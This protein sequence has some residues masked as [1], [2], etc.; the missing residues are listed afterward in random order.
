MGFARLPVNSGYTPSKKQGACQAKENPLR[1]EKGRTLDTYH[2]CAS[3]GFD[4]ATLISV[5]AISLPPALVHPAGTTKQ[6]PRAS[7]TYSQVS[8]AAMSRRW[9]GYPE[10]DEQTVASIPRVTP[11]KVANFLLETVQTQD[12][13]LVDVRRADLTVSLGLLV[14]TLLFLCPA[15]DHC[16]LYSHRFCVFH[17][18]P[19]ADPV[20]QAGP[21][22]STI[23]Q[24]SRAY[25]LPLP[26]HYSRHPWE[27]KSANIL[28]LFI[29]RT[30]PAMRRLDAA[31]LA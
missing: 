30:R 24:L 6:T 23:R 9:V 2:K 31:S 3:V 15:A 11:Q 16:L 29:T 27:Q 14:P 8:P 13:V 20:M 5:T 26:L 25:L 1:S 28:L 21:H 18:T 12:V 7:S 4:Q 19:G 17:T 10:P 22:A